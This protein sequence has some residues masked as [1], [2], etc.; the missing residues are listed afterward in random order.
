MEEEKSNVELNN[1]DD[2]K[3]STEILVDA[4]SQSAENQI[5]TTIEDEIKNEVESLKRTKKKFNS[6]KINIDAM[7]F[8]ETDVGN[9]SV[10]VT[11]LLRHIEKHPRPIRFIQR[12]IPIQR[13]CSA[14][15]AAICSSVTQLI[16]GLSNFSFG[17]VYKQR[18]SDKTTRDEVISA[19]A[20]GVS[21]ACANTS[22]DLGN[23]EIAIIIEVFKNMCGISL[24]R[25]FYKLKKLNV[26]IL[27]GNDTTPQPARLK[28]QRDEDQADVEER[29]SKVPSVA[30]D[31]I[32]QEI[33]VD[34]K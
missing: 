4:S 22:V 21:A 6:R 3:T 31:D 2:S 20:S 32:I 10:F 34:L 12:I 9:P 7:L 16:D 19:V 8:I 30:N 13:T 14:E 27:L 25:D 11:A 18:N 33:A 1:D 26:Q 24:V 15:I 17:I 28:R 5:S 23:P 29:G